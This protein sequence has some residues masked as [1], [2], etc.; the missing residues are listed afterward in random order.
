VI[1]ALSDEG[2]S[3]KNLL[4][5]EL[6]HFIQYLTY[7]NSVQPHGSEFREICRTYGW[8]EEV[9]LAKEKLDP[10][11]L[12][13]RNS[14]E[15]KLIT[16]VSKLLRLASS[17]N[18]Y[19][20]ESAALKANEL[21]LKHNLTKA[22]LVDREDVEIALEKVISFK[23][24]SGKI[25][26]ISKILETFYVDVV[27]NYGSQSA[28]ME[29]M[30]EKTNVEIASYVASFLDQELDNLWEE[31]KKEN[32]SL[33]GQS[34]KNS[35]MKGVAQGF[36]SKQKLQRS[37]LRVDDKA[38]IKMNYSLMKPAK[39]WFF[40]SLGSS[41]Q[42][43]EGSSHSKLIGEKKGKSLSINPALKSSSSKTRMLTHG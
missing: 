27:L 19:E 22:E 39:N 7:G 6:A 21:L 33:K 20:A 10:D 11:K 38:L 32:V 3:L 26:A 16:K 8:G 4:R 2:E 15:N 12:L 35:F 5:H 1:R 28:Y 29:I 25:S 37:E 30:G 13:S 23:R 14:E 40:R 41:S 18:S 31:A 36:L 9:W 24:K 34:Q 43:K 17:E 42:P